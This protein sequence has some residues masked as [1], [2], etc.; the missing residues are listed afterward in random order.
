MG[1]ENLAGTGLASN[2]VWSFTTAAAGTN[3]APTVILTIPLDGA[4]AVPLNQTISATFSE[5][6]NPATINAATFTLTGPGA[7]MVSG[8]VSYA[9][10]GNTLTFT[11]SANLAPSTLFTATITTG[12]QDLAGNALASNFV[13]T[14]T[15]GTTL[16]TTAPEIVSTVPANAAMD[17]A[18]NQ[19]VSATFTEAMN[20]LTITT[21]TF[22]L[23][24][25]GGTAIAGT[26]SYDAL[27]FIAT[28]TPAALLI[29][30]STYTATL[31]AGATD[32]TGNPLGTSGAPN[33]WMFTTGAAVGPTSVNLGTAGLFGAFGGTAGITNQGIF[34]VINGDIG[35]TAVS[36]LITGFND[37]SL[38]V[39][40]IPQ[41]V[42][43]ETPLNIGQV[44]G[45]ID[46]APPPPTVAC[47][48]EGTAV[49]SAIAAKAALDALA[50]YNALVAFPNGLD[51]STCPGCGGGGAGELGNRT[52]APGVYKSAA[53]SYAI[54]MGNLT[55][56]AKGDANAVWVFQ[57]ATTLTV[58]TPSSN[59]SILLVN[60]AQAKNVFWQVGSAAT[61]NGILGG[62]TMQGTIIAQ[63]GV[64][65]STAGVVAVT[66][67]N[68]R[69]LVLTG[70]VTIVNTVIN[71]P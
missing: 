56:D 68:G 11:P 20:P 13:W 58:G 36:T 27:D 47:P 3:T 53:G 22:Q 25:P 61:I 26:V 46:T 18:L 69:A 49:T 62:G 33:P 1:A 52:L 5:A 17:V 60:G 43:T 29:T 66:T 9:A 51:V 38:E 28:F 32:L 64:S 34:T 30:D 10:I 70:P 40:G 42:Y 23:T 37:D 67:L 4:T 39:G 45:V 19:T 54:S 44:N 21:A 8:L 71:V 41:C 50:A 65:V 15:T 48:N 16:N 59:R 35:T 2:Y 6:M 7:T 24:G 55:L 14:F 12:A 57:M 31:T 63:D